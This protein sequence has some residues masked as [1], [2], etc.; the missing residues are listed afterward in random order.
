MSAT[1][2]RYVPAAG[3]AW[4]TGTYDVG[5]A[6]TMREHRWRP[7]LVSAISADLPLNGRAVEVGCGTGSLTL[8]LAAE[9]A[10]AHV[11]GVD[12]DPQILALARRKPGAFRVAW[13]EALAQDL[14]LD[15][16]SIDVA[17]VSLVLHHLGEHGQPAALA[18]IHRVLKP[19][20]ALHVADWGPPRGPAARAGAAA[21]KV[22]D[23]P[24]GVEPLLAGELPDLLHRARFAASR[25]H[26]ALRTMWGTLETWRATAA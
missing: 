19:G 22:F 1:Q 8:A 24:D 13:T 7:H 25:R 17:Y 14:P 15:A 10:D 4:L 6:L 20:G 21:L 3:K 18:E 16:G 11:T 23:G 5:I 26:G 2:E 12:G 9:R